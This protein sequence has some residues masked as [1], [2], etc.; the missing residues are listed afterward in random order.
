MAEPTVGA[1]APAFSAPDQTGKT[2]SLRD[3][4]G[5]TVII[6]FY[7]KDD[8]PGCTAE[9]CSFRDSHD[10][11]EERGVTVLGISPDSVKSHAKFAEKFKLPFP[12]L[13]D[14]GH[15]IAEAYGVWVE[16]SMYGK[17]YMGVE[18]STF[19]IDGVGRLAAIH[20]KVKPAEHVGDLLK[21]L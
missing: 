3:L 20:R 19:V 17:K 9:A 8:T 10:L 18:R 4:A 2:I 13:A 1:K 15:K 21:T 7:P 11:L 14:E 12:L 16:K 5:K 6:Y